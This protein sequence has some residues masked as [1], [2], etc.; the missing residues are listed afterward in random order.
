MIK[1]YYLTVKGHD[2]TEITLDQFLSAER[3]AGFV[4]K[5]GGD[6]ATGGFISGPVSYSIEHEKGDAYLS[7]EETLHEQLD[8]LTV[9]HVDVDSIIGTILI[10]FDNNI[11]PLKKALAEAMFNR[12][13]VTEVCTEY[14]PAGSTY[15]CGWT[16]KMKQWAELAG[17]DLSKRNPAS[18]SNKR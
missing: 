13:I 2:K 12:N 15:E 9:K 7:L 17:V 4:N 10:M 18:Y 5:A 3:Q 8:W 11:Q 14:D 16:D 6:T 1:K